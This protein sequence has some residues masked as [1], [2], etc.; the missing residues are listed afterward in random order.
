MEVWE[1]GWSSCFTIGTLFAV[2][3]LRIVLVADRASHII[4]K[5]LKYFIYHH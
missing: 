2:W 5:K 4:V 1:W 3:D